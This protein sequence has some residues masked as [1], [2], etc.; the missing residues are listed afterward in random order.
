MLRSSDGVVTLERNRVP[1]A[2]GV[3]YDATPLRTRPRDH[4]ENEP[5][6]KPFSTRPPR[7]IPRPPARPPVAVVGPPG[8]PGVSGAPAGAGP[9]PVGDR[10]V[11]DRRAGRCPAFGPRRRG[12]AAEAD[13]RRHA[14]RARGD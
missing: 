6:R 8:A 7:A 4:G 3:W 2:I 13:G 5:H 14:G 1:I 9:A 12:V 11:R 10:H